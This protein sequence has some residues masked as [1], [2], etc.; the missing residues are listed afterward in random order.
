[1][2]LTFVLPAPVRV[3]MGGALVVARHAEGLAARGHTVRVVCPERPGEGWRASAHRLA[4]RVRD[5]WHGVEDAPLLRMRGASLLE[6]PEPSAAFVPDADAVIATGYQTVPWVLAL[7]PEKGEKVYFVQGD[8][9]AIHPRAHDT[10]HAPMARITCARWLAEMLRAEGMPVLGFVPNAVD[11]ATFAIDTPPEARPPGVCAL[12]H[13]HAVK[14]PDVL[15]EALTRLRKAWPGVQADVF[16]ARKPSHR[17]PDWVRVHVR[18]TEYRL[19]A[20]YNR[21]AVLLHTSRREGWALVP[22]E[23]AAC[24]CAVVATDSV[25]VR[26]YLEDG[27]SMRLHEQGDVE[28]LVR[29][30]VALLGDPEARA[31]QAAAAAQ[32]VSRYAW[33]ASTGEMERLLYVAVRGSVPARLAGARAR[34][35]ADAS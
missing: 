20:L 9:R 10:W 33:H 19:R 2:R 5:R 11:P 21:A 29:S 7:P 12:Y 32:A 4:T 27:I 13:R 1:M 22:M 8:E 25:G 28:G 6:V 23:A 14:G 16:S 35:A 17:L 24:G 26:E 15:I 18:P 3:P 34:V 30:A 31:R